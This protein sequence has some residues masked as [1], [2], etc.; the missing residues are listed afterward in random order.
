MSKSIS[1]TVKDPEKSVGDRLLFVLPLYSGTRRVLFIGI[2]G[3]AL[4]EALGK[5]GIVVNH[6][7]LNDEGVID[8]PARAGAGTAAA[9]PRSENEH[10]FDMVIA[11]RL[12][13][14]GASRERFTRSILGLLSPRG[15][16][17]LIIENRFGYARFLGA[18]RKL[19][20]PY[21]RTISRGLM[22]FRGAGEALHR[23]G[24]RS[25]GVYAA[26]PGLDAPLVFFSVDRPNSLESLLA[27]FPDFARKR[28]RVAQGIISLVIRT[29]L[30]RHF[31]NEYVF[32]T[33]PEAERTG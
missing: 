26:V 24:F 2:E 11:G 19:R 12:P 15:H 21:S 30:H 29:N 31:L 28:S 16:F 14:G 1:I 9:A 20:A 13:K 7:A 4:R 23:A 8:P 32:V 10:R 18:A 25:V 27:Q 33:R 5:H 6:A 3:D 17:V 22:S